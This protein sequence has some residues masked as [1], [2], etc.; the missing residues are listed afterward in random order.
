[1][2]T[3]K[4]FEDAFTFVVSIEGGLSL[5]KNDK[6]NWTG[7]VVG[8][9]ALRGTKYGISAARYPD[10]NIMNVTLDYARMLYKRD[11][12]DKCSCG[13][14]PYPVG[15]LIFDCAVNQGEGTARV[16]LQQALNVE[17]DG[18]LGPVTFRALEKADLIRLVPE[19]FTRRV[20]KYT[21]V[22]TFR[23][24]GLGWVRRL[25]ACLVEALQEI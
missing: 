19:I 21:N 3:S 22:D 23:V 25:A 13:K 15:L 20:L 9:G 14:M 11:Y 7:G 16:V 6:G 24:Y 8:Q 12:W 17:T 5:D 18:Q 1:M 10:V 2:P 4:S